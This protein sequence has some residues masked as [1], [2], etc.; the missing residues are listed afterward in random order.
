MFYSS[1]LLYHGFSDHRYFNPQ[2][3]SKVLGNLPFFHGFGYAVF[4]STVV[5]GHTLVV[6]PRF[7]DKIFLKAIQDHKIR[8]LMAVPPLAVFLA[9]SPLVDQYDISCVTDI[10]CGAAPLSKETENL[11]KKRYI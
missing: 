8:F 5:N 10:S 1:Y 9:K 2:P 7:S 11:I 3:N 4:L 6:M